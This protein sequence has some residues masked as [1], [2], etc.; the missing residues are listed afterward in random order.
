M[1]YQQRQEVLLALKRGAMSESVLATVTGL[2]YREL[3]YTVQ[4]LMSEGVLQRLDDGT[5]TIRRKEL[6]HDGW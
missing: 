5:I 2:G 6:S 1:L 3:L 4:V